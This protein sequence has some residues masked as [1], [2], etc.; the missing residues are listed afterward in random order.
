M[1]VDHAKQKEIGATSRHGDKELKDKKA[2]SSNNLFSSATSMI[3]SLLRKPTNIEED[4]DTQSDG[5]VTVV[6]GNNMNSQPV[7]WTRKTLNPNDSEVVRGESSARSSKEKGVPIHLGHF[8][9]PVPRLCLMGLRSRLRLMHLHLITILKI[10]SNRILRAILRTPTRIF[11]TCLY[12]FI[13]IEEKICPRT[14]KILDC[15]GLRARS[16]GGTVTKNVL[17]V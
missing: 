12:N 11:G 15:P 16:M 10:P 17:F 6:P 13:L 1:T 5:S 3:S 2:P 4:D 7:R 9:R 8:V 14:G